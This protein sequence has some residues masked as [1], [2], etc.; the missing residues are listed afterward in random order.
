M[1]ILKAESRSTR[2]PL[3]DLFPREIQLS[4]CCSFSSSSA[5]LFGSSSKSFEI[6]N[7]HSLLKRMVDFEI[8]IVQRDSS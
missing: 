8:D 5:W 3:L 4:L 2:N 6:T 1:M 7:S